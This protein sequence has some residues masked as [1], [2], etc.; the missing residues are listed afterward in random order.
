VRDEDEGVM[1]A[2]KVDRHESYPDLQVMDT[3]KCSS[4]DKMYLF[5][6]KIKNNNLKFQKIEKYLDIDNDLF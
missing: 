2:Y 4:S 6:T 3:A 1:V 5:L